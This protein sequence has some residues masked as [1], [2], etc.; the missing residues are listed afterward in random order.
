MFNLIFRTI[1]DR[2]LSILAYAFGGLLF[3]EMYIAMFP[4]IRDQAAKMSDLFEA[5]PEEFLKIFGLD[6]S[7]LVFDTV[8]KFLA[9]EHFSIVF[10]ILL[11][12]MFI[13]WGGSALAGEI[14]KGT[15]GFLL[16]KPLSRLKIFFAKYISGIIALIVLIS[17]AVMGAIPLAKLHNIAYQGENYLTI[18]ILSFLLGLAVLSVSMFLSALFNDK[19]KAYFITTGIIIVMYVLDIISKLKDNLA[20]LKYA[21]FFYYYDYNS[22]L[23]DNK[24][25]MQSIWIFLG[26][27][28]LF[29]AL[30]AW[31]F[32]RRDISV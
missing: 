6:K 3:M 29:T 1:R 12:A 10:P 14:E 20:D 30:G 2:K 4:S 8:E 21:S 25:E 16:A 26:I 32:N 7:S 24:I 27:T 17:F 15:M 19:G 28:V 31:W 22:A 18:S 13:S 9:V 5:Y 23:L 11:F